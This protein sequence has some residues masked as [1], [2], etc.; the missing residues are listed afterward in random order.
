AQRFF[1]VNKSRLVEGAYQT[2]RVRDL[3]FDS[4]PVPRIGAQISRTQ[5]VRGEHR[6]AAAE[7][8]N[9]IA[10][11]NCAVA[12]RPEQE[13]GARGRQWQRVVVDRKLKPAEISAGVADG[14]LE[15]RKLI[16]PA[17]RHVTGPC[18][19]HGDVETVGKP[20]RGLDGDL[21]PAMA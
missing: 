21:A 14:P 1:K 15:N 16:G 19:K 3:S 20:L 12:R 9:Q 2:A 5:F 11:R 18:E 4:G 17:R 6:S 8:E 10:G 13:L 7:I